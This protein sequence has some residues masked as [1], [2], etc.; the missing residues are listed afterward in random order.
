MT[1]N[2]AGRGAGES[3]GDARAPHT[4]ET[5]AASDPK[6]A[7]VPLDAQIEEAKKL[8][9]ARYQTACARASRGEISQAAAD[10]EIA[11]VRA[12]KNTLV[13]VAENA[14]V[15]RAVYAAKRQR[16]IENDEIE[17]LRSHP[18]VAPVLEALPGAEIRTVRELVAADI[19]AKASENTAAT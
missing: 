18:A 1:T 19:E 8:L 9:R 13:W 7:R 12:I 15:F 2:A 11:T 10:R 16:E 5:S 3:E 14:D 4:R 17:E 6:R